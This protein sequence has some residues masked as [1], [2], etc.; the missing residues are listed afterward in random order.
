MT[1]GAN[2]H[3]YPTSMTHERRILKETAVITSCTKFDPVLLVGTT[4]PG[5]AERE[6]LDS[7][8]EVMR[9]SRRLPVRVPGALGK[10]LGVALW[11]ARVWRS[12]SGRPIACVN[13]HSLPVLPLAVALKLRAGARLVYDT[14]EL[15]TE[16]NGL[17]GLRRAASKVVE[18]MLYRFVD[19]T[20]VVSDSI[21]EWYKRTY[22]GRRPAVVLNCPPRGQPLI[23]NRLRA[24]LALQPDTTLFLYQGVLSPGRGIELLL[25]AFA[26]I[27]DPRKT[28]VF[29]GSGPL[30]ARI[31]ECARARANVRMHPVVP[32]EELAGFT[33]SAD[34]GLCLIEDTCLSYR[35]CMPNKLF[36]YLAAGV[37]TLVSNLPEIASVVSRF[38]AGWVLDAWSVAAL[39]S[40]FCSTD[41]QAI[42]DRRAGTARAAD[43]YAWESQV[44]VLRS[45]YERLDLPSGQRRNAAG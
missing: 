27:E 19:E 29:M 16:T 35:Y 45:V 36:E 33:A 11:S 26:G 2:V 40:F 22:G 37:P 38:E 9:L 3:L 7:R 5:L 34:V 28:L 31:A 17:G 44:P 41:A 6:S 39:R 4:A 15:E 42:R 43:E 12:L 21:A 23:S 1:V 14:H 25:E 30:E 8:R 20:V 13:C 24:A 18:R 32:P 10:A